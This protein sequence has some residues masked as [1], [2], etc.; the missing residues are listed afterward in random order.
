MWVTIP[1]LFVTLNVSCVKPVKMWL[2]FI[3]FYLLINKINDGMTEKKIE[4]AFKN[5]NGIFYLFKLEELFKSYNGHL[6]MWNIKRIECFK[7]KT[8]VFVPI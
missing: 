4:S 1:N 8:V 2:K 7:F 3:Y 6:F 5:V